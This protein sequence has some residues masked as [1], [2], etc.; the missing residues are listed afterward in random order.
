M[1]MDS[2]EA[3]TVTL[4]TLTISIEDTVAELFAELLFLPGFPLPLPL[5]LCALWIIP[6]VL[7]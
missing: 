2:S 6:T 3:G 1:Q 5:R 7:L 4:G